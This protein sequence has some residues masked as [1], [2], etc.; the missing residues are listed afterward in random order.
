MRKVTCEDMC[1]K[2]ESLII[3]GMDGRSVVCGLTRTIDTLLT[4]AYWSARKDLNQ[5]PQ[6][7]LALVALGGY[8]CRELFPFS[9]I[10]ILLL[11]RNK[12]SITKETAESVLYSLWDLGLNI[13]HSFRTMDECVEDAMSDMKTRTSLLPSR[14]I[15]GSQGLFQEF[16]REAYQKILYRGKKKFVGDIL[17]EIEKRHKLYGDS[18]YLL[19]PNVK[20][21]RG[22]LRDIHSISWLM[23]IVS[24]ISDLEDYRKVISAQDYRDFIK[25]CDFLVKTRISLHCISGRKNDVLSLDIQERVSKILRLKD[26]KKFFCAEVLMRLYYKK[27]KNI[28][29]VLTHVIDLSASS[30]FRL[31]VSFGFKKITND[32]YLSRNELVVKDKSVLDSPDKILEAFYIYASTEKRFSYQIKDILRSKSLLIHKKTT[33]SS[34][35]NQFFLDILRSNRVYETLHEM[36]ETGI[37]DRVLP[38]FGRIRHLVVYEPSHRYTVDEHSLIAIRNLEELKF[39]KHIKLQYLSDI[40]KTVKQEVL[41]LAVLLHD[42]GKGLSIPHVEAG[43]RIIKGILERFNIAADDRKRIEFLVKEHVVLSTL[44]LTRDTE[45]QETIAQ[46]ADVVDNEE[47]LNALY[48]MTYADM[49]AVNPHFWTEWKAYLFLDLYR[50]TRDH[51]RGMVAPHAQITDAALQSFIEDMPA[52]YL[53]SNTLEDIKMDFQ[54]AQELTQE[55][56]A[57]SIKEKTDGTAE[58][59]IITTDRIGLFSKILSVLSVRELNICRARLYTGE[60]GLVVDKV[61]ISNWKEMC[62]E[63]MEKQ[64]IEDLTRVIVLN[65]GSPPTPGRNIVSK[66]H[67]QQSMVYKRFEPFIEIDNE[68]SKE[69]TLFEL[70]LP[71]RIG[72]LFDISRQLNLHEIDIISAII[73]TEDAIAQD[74]FYLQYHGAKLTG[75]LI[76]K[77]LASI[78]EAEMQTE[79][80]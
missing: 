73:N 70:L 42:I 56:L 71:D 79:K 3:S 21:G 5:L 11:A 58:F 74:V 48:L 6:D 2:A 59:I 57:V 12:S 63:G 14:F 20:E 55:R 25:A 72:L 32:F 53:I 52:R 77:L 49:T 45:A 23:R 9:D 13:S 40:L 64:I 15:T 46:V 80:V 28:T 36:H 41:F 30:F 67:A 44:A 51:L 1:I 35:T 68:S 37:L 47:N 31:P 69:Y 17:R 66:D 50:K 62:W 4:E 65:A 33:T 16:K 26:T 22:G 27:V 34:K 7:N 75:N 18:L 60:S 39:T 61:F 19:E 8:G 76:V 10:D 29:D 54:I 43:Y 38:E 24:K 78:Y